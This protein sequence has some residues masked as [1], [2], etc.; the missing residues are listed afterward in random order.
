MLKNLQNS[1]HS[2]LAKAGARI[3]TGFVGCMY[4]FSGKLVNGTVHFRLTRPCKKC[5]IL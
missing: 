2:N 5:K 1:N 4:Y 3:E